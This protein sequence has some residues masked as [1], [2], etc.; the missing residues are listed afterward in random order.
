MVLLI[1]S[2]GFPPK[3]SHIFPKFSIAFHPKVSYGNRLEVF[4]WLSFKRSFHDF[5]LDFVFLW[6]S[7]WYSSRRNL[8]INLQKRFLKKYPKRICGAMCRWSFSERIPRNFEISSE[9]HSKTLSS[10]V[11]NCSFFILST[12]VILFRD[13]LQS[14]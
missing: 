14:F 11:S 1:T 12:Y 4:F 9:S 13:V 6:S 8:R 7:F 3:S 10:D 5:F 2:A